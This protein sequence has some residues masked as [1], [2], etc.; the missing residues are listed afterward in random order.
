MISGFKP[1][2]VSFRHVP[3][4]SQAAS[5]SFR[6]LVK[7]PSFELTETAYADGVAAGIRT[8]KA[9]VFETASCAVPNEATAT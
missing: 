8:P 9:T 5:L 7:G 1:L 2:R 4:K 3:V 6:A